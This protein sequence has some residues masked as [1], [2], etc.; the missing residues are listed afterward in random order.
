MP[1]FRFVA[2]EEIGKVSGRLAQLSREIAKVPDD[3]T[4]FWQG[5]SAVCH[6]ISGLLELISKAID[7]GRSFP[8]SEIMAL[9]ADIEHNTL[10][11]KYFHGFVGAPHPQD[12]NR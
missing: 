10:E 11:R 2:G 4:G 3:G 5:M 9:L 6:D 1:E 8:R 12:K 7:E